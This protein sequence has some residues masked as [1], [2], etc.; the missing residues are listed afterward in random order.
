MLKE[1]LKIYAGSTYRSYSY[2]EGLYN[3]YV[4]KDGFKE[5]ETYSA[6]AGYSEHQLGL[7]VD[8][9]MVNGI[10]LVK[11]IKNILGLLI[12]HINMFYT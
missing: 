5:A 10:I 4:K 6:R 2:Q 8:I 7:A 11:V 12:I 3:R 9:V 1:N